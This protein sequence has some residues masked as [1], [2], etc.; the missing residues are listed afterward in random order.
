MNIANKITVSRFGLTLIFVLVA[1]LDQS[2][3]FRWIALIVA[4]CAAL[5]DFLDGYLARKHKLVTDFGKLMDPLADKILVAAAF[6]ILCRK[7][8]TPDWF[9]IIIVT[10]E[11]AVTGLRQIAASNNIIIQADNSG[12]IKTALQ[13][14]YLGIVALF[15]ATKGSHQE[16]HNENLNIFI[17]ILMLATTYITL[18]SGYKYFANNKKLFNKNI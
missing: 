4:T 2:A 18:S 15:W 6:F 7:S 12:K 10:R 8:I 16:I 17:N 11:F 9:A 5:S 1:Q 13:F 14:T 3:F